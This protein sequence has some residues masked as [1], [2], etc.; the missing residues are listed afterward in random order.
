M[1]TL[2]TIAA[3]ALATTMS[4]CSLVGGEDETTADDPTTSAGAAESGPITLVTHESFSLPKPL[5]KQFAKETGRQ[6]KI[7]QAGDAGTLTTKLALSAGN[8]EGDVAFGVDN[9]FASRALSEDVFESSDIER[10]A[11]S[12]AFDLPDGSDKMVPIDTASVCVNADTTWFEDHT[13]DVP[14]TFDDLADP[15]YKA[16]LVA[17]GASTS[18]PGLAFLLATIAEK[19]DGWQDYWSDLMAND[20]QLVKGWSDAYYTDFTFSG[21]DRPLVVSY[22]TSPAFTVSKDGKQ[23]VTQVLDDTCF[24]QVE[25]AG[26]LAGTDNPEGAAQVVEWLLSPEVQAAIPD[27]MY[28]YPVRDDVELPADWAKFAPRA[29]DPITMDPAEIADNRETW[30]TEWTDVTTR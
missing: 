11:G 23:T 27:A 5:L 28:V 3:L 15:A 2:H 20:T 9:T 14:Q 22:D 26:V 17:P 19:G 16:L 24:Q 30:L 13:L 21:G 12:D 29:T 25:Y 7:V 4:A 1:K 6:I 18:S 8:P 10:P